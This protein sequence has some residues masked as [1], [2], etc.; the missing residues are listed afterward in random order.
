MSHT[1]ASSVRKLR[2]REGIFG[3]FPPIFKGILLNAMFDSNTEFCLK[4][5]HSEDK[6]RQTPSRKF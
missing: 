3:T 4:E 1:G 6:P 2:E 5:N